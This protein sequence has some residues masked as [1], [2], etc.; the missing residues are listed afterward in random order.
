[1]QKRLIPHW[2]FIDLRTAGLLFAAGWTYQ[3]PGH[4]VF[5]GNRPAFA[6]SAIQILIAPLWLA[7]VITGYNFLRKKF[8]NK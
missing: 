8:E 4:F 1:M 7:E 2:G 6:K 5:E 3:I